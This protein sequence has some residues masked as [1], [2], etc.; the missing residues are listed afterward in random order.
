V[1][2]F[3]VV[4]DIRS[5]LSP[6]EV[7]P[8]VHAFSLQYTEEAL[9]GSVVRAASDSTHAAQEPMP[10]EEAL[11]LI[12]GELATAVR[13]QDHGTT[14]LSLPQSHQDGLENELPV[15]A[16]THR[17]AHHTARVE[18]QD[19]AEVQPAFGGSDVGDVRDPLRVGLV[20][21]EVTVQMIPNMI[22]ARA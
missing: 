10:L 6:R 4:E 21:R 19:D 8:P 3:D 7:L 9:S 5:S 17:P 13:V 11:I 22:R 1:K 12:A 2:A 20:R 16:R 18:I 15:L 14:I